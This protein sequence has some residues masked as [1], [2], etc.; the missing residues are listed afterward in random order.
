M[1][2]DIMA[3]AIREEELFE[4]FYEKAAMR[5]GNAAAKTLFLRLA[6]EERQHKLKLMGLHINVEAGPIGDDLALTPLNEL[7]TIKDVFHHAITFEKKARQKY[8]RFAR[9]F[10]EAR[11][12]FTWLADEERKHEQLLTAELKRAGV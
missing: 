11:E 4:E 8:L 1:S 10:S 2:L 7:Q 6:D 12:L 3:R 9:A 5:T